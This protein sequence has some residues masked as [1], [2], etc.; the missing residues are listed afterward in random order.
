MP[1]VKASLSE[2]KRMEDMQEMLSQG[3]KKDANANADKDTSKIS[4]LKNLILLG[5]LV[6][7]VSIAGFNFK[8]STLS[9]KEQS[10]IMKALMKSDEIDRVLNSK[11]IAVSYCIKEINAVSLSELSLEHDGETD[12]ERRA[13]FVMEMQATLVDKIFTEYE[14]LVERSNQE[15]GFDSVK[16]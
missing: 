7:V 10:Q 5:K 6:E 2:N 8:L 4:D 15:V 12:E 1:K 9:T 16:K 3:G 14:K 13:S 11:A